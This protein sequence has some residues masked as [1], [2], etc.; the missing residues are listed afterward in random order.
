M[1]AASPRRAARRDGHDGARRAARPDRDDGRAAG[2]A[3]V[4]VGRDVRR[5]AR[6]REQHVAQPRG[7]DQQQR[8]ALAT[9]KRRAVL[10]QA[11]DPDVTE[12]APSSSERAS[13]TESSLTG[14]AAA[15]RA[16]VAAGVAPGALFAAGACVLA[17]PTRQHS[18]ANTPAPGPRGPASSR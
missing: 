4:E 1:R 16:A 10:E 17:H 5:Q 15:A 11:I 13:A 3:E 18:S 8:T 6:L 2:R 12:T 9:E 7:V 14:A